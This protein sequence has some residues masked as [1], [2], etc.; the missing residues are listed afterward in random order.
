MLD[1]NTLFISVCVT[2][3]NRPHLIS[4]CIQSILDQSYENFE[5]IITDN[6]ENNDTKKIVDDFADS[7]IRYFKHE[8][9]VGLAKNMIK[10]VSMASGDFFTWLGDDDRMLPGSL[11]KRIH[12]LNKYPDLNIVGCGYSMTSSKGVLKSY[13]S[14]IDG[15]K[16]PSNI[17]IPYSK[18][19][20]SI[21][22]PYVS[23][24]LRRSIYQDVIK[25]SYNFYYESFFMYIA[26]S[27][28]NEIG[29]VSETL[30]HLISQDHYRTFYIGNTL[31]KDVRDYPQLFRN[32][33]IEQYLMAIR[34]YPEVTDIL[35]TVEIQIG[36]VEKIISTFK[37]RNIFLTW[38]DINYFSVNLSHIGF[39][40]TFL[41]AYSHNKFIFFKNIKNIFKAIFFKLIKIFSLNKKSVRK[42]S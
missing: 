4:D 5:L 36:L 28:E 34:F 3:Y 15:D 8:K 16:V 30:Y 24:L 35:N 32:L 6:S 1:K 37:K 10:A 31:V 9:N 26:G 41:K 19:Y 18:N 38:N 22:V 14:S 13:C 21:S 25:Y 42:L 29:Y 39:F 20:Q 33:F 7:R 17:L 23:L 40:N 27:K 11:E 2:T 12:L